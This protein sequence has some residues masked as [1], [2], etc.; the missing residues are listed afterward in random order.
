MGGRWA[1]RAAGR[2]V[3]AG[4]DVAPSGVVPGPTRGGR[5]PR[6]GSGEPEVVID[7]RE[8]SSGGWAARVDPDPVRAAELAE[9]FRARAARAEA[10]RELLRLR[11]RHWS[12]SRL[13]EEGRI[14]ELEWWEHAEAD[15]YAVLGLMP[16][17]KLED[18]AA[19]RRRIAQRCHPDRAV[20]SG[21]D[22]ELAIR[23]M[24]AANAAYDRLRRALLT[25]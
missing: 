18:A 8:G 4:D 22:P 15:P 9:R 14:D 23:R 17:A 2:R 25:V 5:A 20:E 3:A 19:A 12:G 13:I 7:L 6:A 21:E 24:V 16:G 1:R 11:A 10:Q